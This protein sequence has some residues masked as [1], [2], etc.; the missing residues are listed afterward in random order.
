MTAE[1]LMVISSIHIL[2]ADKEHPRPVAFGSGCIIEHKERFFLVSVRHVT[3]IEGLT[4]FLE[5]NLPSDKTTTPIQPIGGLCYFDLF[6]VG[7]ASKIKEFDDLIMNGKRLDITFAEIKTNIELVQPETDFGAF[8][9]NEGHKHILD[10]RD[11][12]V[13][14]A[15]DTYGFFGRIKQEYDGIYLK[16]ENALKHG[17]KYHRTDKNFHLFLA[18][19]T[20]TDETEYQGCSGAPILDSQGRLVALACKVLIP[21]RV[22]YGFS[23]QEC[24]RLLDMAIKNRNVVIFLI[25]FQLKFQQHSSPE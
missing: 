3:D 20:I 13:P 16:I 15:E 17:L 19:S 9:V 12:A 21:S 23:I 1:E 18:T 14:N 7:D 10:T 4:T 8:K 2:M 5:T 6:K 24:I 11:I 25:K 22:I